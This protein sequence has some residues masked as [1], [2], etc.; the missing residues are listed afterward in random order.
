MLAEQ[1]VR[2]EIIPGAGAG[3]RLDRHSQDQQPAVNAI[4][5]PGQFRTLGIKG[6]HDPDAKPEK[7]C[8]EHD[9]AEQENAIKTLRAL[10]DHCYFPKPMMRVRDGGLCSTRGKTGA[11]I[12]P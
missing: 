4:P 10:R 11:S 2:H 8:D 5:A 1:F 7:D 3:Q 6:D 12:S 9:L